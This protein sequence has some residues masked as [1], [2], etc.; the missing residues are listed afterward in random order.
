MSIIA[1]TDHITNPDIERKILGD[2]VGMQV[3]KDTEVILVWH[4]QIN[5]EF[6]NKTPNLRGVQRYGVGYDTLDLK[7]LKSRGMVV[8]NNPDYGVDEVSDAAVAMIMNIAR[9]IT[10]YNHHAKEYFDTWQENVNKRIKR[11]SEI[12]LGVIGAGRIGGAVI[13]KSNTLKF[14]TIF[15][16]KYKEKGHEKVLSAERVDSLNELLERSDIISIHVPLTDETKNMVDDRFLKKMKAGASLVNTARGALFAS[17]DDIFHALKSNTL[18]Q[19]ATDVLP[20]EPPLKGKLIDAWRNSEK[21][22]NGRLIINPHTSFYSIQSLKEM[23]I[24]A[25]KNALRILKNEEPYN[26]IV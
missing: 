8:C 9:G 24:N 22:I 18:Y 25:A 21:W 13:L 11:N 5:S 3:D 14:N 2:L 17:M 20:E 19:L 6:L 12:T 26:R 1:I 7:E 10:M 4:E 16:D 23:R 15:Y